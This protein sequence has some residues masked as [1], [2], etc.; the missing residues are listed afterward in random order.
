MKYIVIWITINP[1]LINFTSGTQ[2]CVY[3]IPQQSGYVIVDTLEEAKYFV[4]THTQ[5]EV[6][7]FKVSDCKELKVV[8][9]Q[10]PVEKTITEIKTIVSLEEK[11]SDASR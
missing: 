2:D 7:V 10:V 1:N 8:K 4:G 6:T 5:H 11:S 9:N 3:R